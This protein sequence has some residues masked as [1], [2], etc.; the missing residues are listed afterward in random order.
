MDRLVVVIVSVTGLF[1]C[2]PG[3]EPATE[4]AAQAGNLSAITVNYPL[5]YF[6]ER[7]G[8]DAVEV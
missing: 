2:R 6:S 5:C 4:G 8:G 3:D 7:I 1:A